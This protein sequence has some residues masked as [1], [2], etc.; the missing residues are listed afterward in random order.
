M[1]IFVCRGSYVLWRHF[2]DANNTDQ[3]LCFPLVQINPSSCF[4]GLHNL[5]LNL[6]PN[7]NYGI[8]QMYLNIKMD[9]TSQ[10]TFATKLVNHFLP[11]TITFINTSSFFP[12][13]I[14]LKLALCIVTNPNFTL[15]DQTF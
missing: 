8:K 11:W 2:M 9:P 3:M 5:I 7:T 13:F 10:L 1:K 12:Y 15:H 14:I 6:E 4:L